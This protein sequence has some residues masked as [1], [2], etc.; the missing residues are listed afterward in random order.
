MKFILPQPCA[1][2][3]IKSSKEVT[4]VH[5]TK[6]ANFDPRYEKLLNHKISHPS[7]QRLFNSRTRF[8]VIY[9]VSCS[10]SD[11]ST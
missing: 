3:K 6:N 1:R 11:I 2:Q 9:L 7:N 10:V 8:Q 5:R 4:I